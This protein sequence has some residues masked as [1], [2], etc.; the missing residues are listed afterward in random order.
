MLQPQ[1]F[2]VPQLHHLLLQPSQVPWVPCC[3]AAAPPS[4]AAAAAVGAAAASAAQRCLTAVA[5]STLIAAIGRQQ[6]RQHVKACEAELLQVWQAG[7]RQPQQRTVV[8]RPQLILAAQLQAQ[9]LRAIL[10][11]PG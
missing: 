2:K 9:Q 10:G 8:T 1:L 4:A 11:Q 3:T 6:Q 7:Q 5:A